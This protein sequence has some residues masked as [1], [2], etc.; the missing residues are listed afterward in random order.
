MFDPNK[1]YKFRGYDFDPKI[2][3]TTPAGFYCVVWQEPECDEPSC[4]FWYKN[5]SFFEKGIDQYDL[6]NYEVKEV[7][8]DP[9]KP[10]QY[11][12]GMKAYILPF[13]SSLEE[14]PICSVVIIDNNIRDPII[15]THMLDGRQMSFDLNSD[16]DLV[17]I[18]ENE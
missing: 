2:V 11:R 16:Y 9:K 14:Y 12:N 7:I 10:Y 13:K 18:L 8:F 6:V 17:N 5:G 3:Y 4:D 15:I 1:P